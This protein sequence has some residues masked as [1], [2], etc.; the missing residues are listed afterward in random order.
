MINIL[1]I[2]ILFSRGIGV[3]ALDH[4]LRTGWRAPSGI[5][6]PRASG[7]KRHAYQVNLDAVPDRT[8][9]KKIR[10]ADKLSKMSVL[11]AADAL[12]DSGIGNAGQNR[13]GII[14]STAFGAHVTT[15]DFLDGILDYGEANVSPTVFS[16][17]VHNAAASY[18]SS[19]LDIKG[20]TLSVTQ[21]RFSFQAALQLAQTWLDQD[22]CDYVLV[23]AADQ[24]GDVLG[25]VAGQKLMSAP[26]GKIKPFIFSPA[27][28]VPG[29]GA[30]FFMLGKE[31]SGTK[32]CLVD[33]VHTSEDPRDGSHVDINI[34][35]ADG[36]LP[37]E[38][39]YRSVLASDIPAAAYSPLFGSMM[40]T[41]AFSVAA[42]AITIKNQFLYATPVR[43]NVSGLNLLTESGESKIGSIRCTGFNCYTD[44]S[45][46]YLDR[47]PL[48]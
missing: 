6:V 36:M 24:Y 32:Y 11:A 22:R 28:H 25:Y 20:P 42:G 23:G 45:V 31:S 26:D 12:K 4:A 1:G 37:D 15:F 44:K 18:I 39:A 34:I 19:S 16:N 8:L 27:C 9:L 7:I 3:A 47:V 43:D 14:L 38:S 30:V 13:T 41:S 29:E 5:D 33:A 46:I 10:R 40:I 21:F 35:D 17:S 2:G 48:L